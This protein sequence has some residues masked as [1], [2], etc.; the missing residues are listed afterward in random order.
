MINNKPSIIIADDD[1]SIIAA[2]RLLLK[3]HNY[4]VT[5]VSSP[6][7]LLDAVKRQEY[8]IALIDL[9]YRADTT[10]GQEGFDLLRQLKTCDEELPV[11]VMTGYGSI[12]IAV[13]AMKLG[14]ADF[15]QKPWG[16][17]R[18]LTVLQSQINIRAIKY[19]GSKLAEENALLRQQQDDASAS[20]VAESAAMKT[21]IAQ[22]E[23]LAISEMNILIT[24]ENGTGK[25]LLAKH[26]HQCSVRKEQAFMSVNM[27]AIAENLFESEMFG[28]I[29]GAFT[30]AKNARIGRFELAESGSLFLDEIANIPLAQQGKLLRVLEEH[31]FEKVGS[32]KTQKAD[33]RIISATNADLTQMINDG[34]FRQDLLY[35]LNTVVVEIPPLRARKR[36]ILALAE[37]FLQ[38]YSDKYRL[39][40]KYF[41][42]DAQEM[43][44]SYH[45]PGNI[46]ELNH[47]VERAVF[48]CHSDSITPDALGIQTHTSANE[49]VFQNESI[50]SPI[51]FAEDTLENI[52]RQ[53]IISRLKR[54]DNNY[55]QTAESLGLSKS[56]Y[57]RRLEKHQL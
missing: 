9:N 6:D 25:S 13:K 27:G 41:S 56:A 50:D 44:L 35:R 7:E 48:L 16:N 19:R 5:A 31:S 18:L 11:V 42:N 21:L 55:Q 28:H 57:Y 14:A 10:S 47:M 34:F 49:P 15:V 26:I 51:G 39:G 4:I 30:D 43:L 36:D 53:I 54:F 37:R 1:A 24:G 45:W 33:V 52:E 12:D 29:K 32:S 38:N 20:I 22:L 17:D 46:R 8:S 2:L 3:N 40:K 23:R